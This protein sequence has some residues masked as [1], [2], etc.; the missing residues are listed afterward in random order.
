MAPARPPLRPKRGDKTQQKNAGKSSD[1]PL[2]LLRLLL[3]FNRW[4]FDD[5]FFHVVVFEIKE[6]GV[7]F[8]LLSVVI[9]ALRP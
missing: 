2:F 1:S 7:F 9:V 3:H 4:I 8:L 5:F 6:I